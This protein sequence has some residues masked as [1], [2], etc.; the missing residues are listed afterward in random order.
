MGWRIEEYFKF[1]KQSFD[2]KNLR[3]QSL[4]SI[5]NLDFMFTMTI[6]YIAGIS[7]KS[8]TSKLRM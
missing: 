2:F 8:Y 7:G 1:N 5:R 3:V 6:G 4:K